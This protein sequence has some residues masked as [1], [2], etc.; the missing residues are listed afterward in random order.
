MAPCQN[1]PTVTILNA[2]KDQQDDWKILQDVIEDDKRVN[3]MEILLK[4]KYNKNSL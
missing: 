3:W 1:G 4:L 2:E